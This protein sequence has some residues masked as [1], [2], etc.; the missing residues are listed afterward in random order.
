MFFRFM[1]FAP[2]VVCS[3]EASFDTGRQLCAITLLPVF[4]DLA[5][6]I[7]HNSRANSIFGSRFLFS[8]ITWILGND[9]FQNFALA[10]ADFIA[11]LRGASN[12]GA[13]RQTEQIGVPA[14][15]CLRVRIGLVSCIGPD[16]PN[17]LRWR[18]SMPGASRKG[19]LGGA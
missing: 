16:S 1:I 5:T 3:L 11:R 8:H 19:A 2:Y 6:C 7:V 15:A 13:K 10:G 18:L 12:K 14:D 17:E 4:R 9:P